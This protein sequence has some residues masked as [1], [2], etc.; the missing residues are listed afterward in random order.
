[1]SIFVSLA[2]VLDSRDTVPENEPA[3]LYI[4]QF[5]GEEG[6]EEGDRKLTWENIYE[7]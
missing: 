3:L 2:T 7:S 1:L 5:E 6:N 4:L